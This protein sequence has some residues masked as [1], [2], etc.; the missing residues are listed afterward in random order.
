MIDREQLQVELLKERLPD[1]KVGIIIKGIDRIS[2]E[3][4]IAR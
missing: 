4:V 2:P 1:I 3:R